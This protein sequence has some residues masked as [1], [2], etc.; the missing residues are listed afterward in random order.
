MKKINKVV[1]NF[2]TIMESSR[3]MENLSAVYWNIFYFAVVSLPYDVC[4]YSARLLAKI[5]NIPGI[6]AILF[7]ALNYITIINLY[8]YFFIKTVVGLSNISHLAYFNLYALKYW[9]NV[10]LVLTNIHSNSL[11]NW[12]QTTC[13]MFFF[14]RM[15]NW[16]LV[17][18][19]LST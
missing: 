14:P 15:L 13:L 11:I 2:I 4:K 9:R 12:P 7:L 3:M 19:I 6:W 16:T 5:K 10:G 1:A 17:Q 18:C 8:I